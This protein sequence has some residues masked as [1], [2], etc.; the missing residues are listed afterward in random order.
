VARRVA[1]RTGWGRSRPVRGHACAHGCTGRGLDRAHDPVPVRCPFISTI[2][3]P[4][5][6]NQHRKNGTPDDIRRLAGQPGVDINKATSRGYTVRA[7]SIL[8]V[9]SQCTPHPSIHPSGPPRVQ[10]H[11]G[12]QG[13]AGNPPHPRGRHG[14]QDKA[15]QLGAAPGRLRCIVPDRPLRCCTD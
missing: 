9:W 1:G 2:G 15:G 10:R 8:R 7:Q 13:T 5:Q 14:P 4:T 6:T 11:K 12:V 3:I